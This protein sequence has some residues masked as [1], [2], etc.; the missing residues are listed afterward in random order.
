VFPEHAELTERVSAVDQ[1]L[2]SSFFS[3]RSTDVKEPW[4]RAGILRKAGSD[5]AEYCRKVFSAP[6]EI[7]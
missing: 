4:W 1:R 7:G 5:Y 3:D 2:R 6:V